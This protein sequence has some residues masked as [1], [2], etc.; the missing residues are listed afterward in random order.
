MPDRILRETVR[1]LLAE[2]ERAGAATNGPL[3]IGLAGAQGAGKTTVA[4]ALAA[5]LGEAGRK[6]AALSLDDFYLSRAE[7]RERAAQRHP[8]FVTRGV[9][10][11]HDV[12]AA[13]AALAA[14]KAG[15]GFLAPR[16]D[17]ALDERRPRAQ[18]RQVAGG[19]DALIFEGWCLGAR[20]QPEDDL[21]EPINMLERA[22]DRDGRWRRAVNCAL[23]GEYQSLF[24]LLDRLIFLRAPDFAVVERWRA[25]QERCAAPHASAVMTPEEISFFIQYFERITR[26]MLTELPERADLTLWLDERRRVVAAVRAPG[27]APGVT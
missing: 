25:E 7:R 24:G 15:D 18:W 9:P 20:P 17:K 22:F 10:G 14:A 6:S 5:A 1:L 16:F 21:A 19:L 26:F 27:S 11:T 12:A 2:I 13:C 23:G 3:L 4:H 8:L